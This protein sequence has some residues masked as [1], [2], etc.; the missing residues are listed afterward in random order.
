MIWIKT[1]IVAKSET[2]AVERRPRAMALPESSHDPGADYRRISAYEKHIERDARDGE[3]IGP[4]RC[5]T[6]GGKPRRP[7]PR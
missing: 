7:E 2:W 3:P 1:S 4:S 6:R 5:P